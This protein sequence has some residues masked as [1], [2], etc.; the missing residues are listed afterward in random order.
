MRL[1]YAET[2]SQ[3]FA[4]TFST[5][6]C[7]SQWSVKVGRCCNLVMMQFTAVFTFC[8][9]TKEEIINKGCSIAPILCLG[10]YTG[11]PKSPA[12][13]PNNFCVGPI[14]NFIFWFRYWM[15]VLFL[16]EF[17]KIQGLLLGGLCGTHN[18]VCLVL[19]FIFQLTST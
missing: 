5:F 14:E 7:K 15:I 3:G 16:G 17:A 8:P 4:M 2:P 1:L 13:G 12:T 11:C 10:K 6:I 18:F 19:Y 9:A